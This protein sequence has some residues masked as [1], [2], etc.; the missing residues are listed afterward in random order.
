MPG[1]FVVAG[2]RFTPEQR[3]DFVQRMIALDRERTVAPF[4][5]RREWIIETTDDDL[6]SI[7]CAHLGVFAKTTIATREVPRRLTAVAFG[8]ISL[9]EGEPVARMPDAAAT[10]L[11]MYLHSGSELAERIEGDFVIVI[12]DP[13][14]KRLLVLND[15]L[16]L[17]PHYVADEPGLFAMAPNL[18]A[19]ACLPGVDD[20]VDMVGLADL[21]TFGYILADDTIVRGVK[22]LPPASASEYREGRW[23]TRSYWEL[24]VEPGR[25]PRASTQEHI[26]RIGELMSDA[27]RRCVPTDGQVTVSLS[28]GLDSRLVACALHREGI[29]FEAFTRGAEDSC[30]VRFSRLLCERLGIRQR[31]VRPRHDQ[32]WERLVWLAARQ[33]GMLNVVHNFGAS[34]AIS[35]CAEDTSCLVTGFLGGP[36]AG[37]PLTP[38]ARLLAPSRVADYALGQ[39][40]VCP[41]DQVAA[42]APGVARTAEQGIERVGDLLTAAEGT[43][44]WAAALQFNLAQRQRKYMNYGNAAFRG[45]FEC[46]MPIATAA[47]VDYFMGLPFGRLFLRTLYR[48]AI[49]SLF[50]AVADIPNDFVDLPPSASRLRVL[51]RRMGKPGRLPASV[52]RVW[53]RLFWVPDHPGHSYRDLDRVWQAIGPAAREMVVGCRDVPGLDM[54]GV[55][56]AFDSACM[57]E[58]GE[59]DLA[60]HLLT[61]VL[62]QASR[63]RKWSLGDL[64]PKSH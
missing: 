40:T 35:D 59:L 22:V 10:A 50:P 55:L 56:A 47:V 38:A 24:R 41:R 14:E 2:E 29:E 9:R 13:S 37:H 49:G 51:F 21:L 6:A 12:S 23:R 60:Q 43:P 32:A 53:Q 58:A 8:N 28:G 1:V 57:T 31:T 18:S 36:V 11:E 45:Q 27:V 62:W 26:E 44:G 34:H 25:T 5:P 20:E 3:A 48:Q 42:V 54:Q 19:V 46:A 15:R 16:G 30:E 7:G 64:A 33:D 4:G 52:R 17:V 39:H 61:Y 63:P